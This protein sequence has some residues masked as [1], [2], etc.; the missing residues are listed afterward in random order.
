MSDQLIR[1]DIDA[2]QTMP[3]WTELMRQNDW[4]EPLAAT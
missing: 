4:L 1:F 3:W 2:A